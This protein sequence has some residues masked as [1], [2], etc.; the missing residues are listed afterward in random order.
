MYAVSYRVGVEDSNA[1]SSRLAVP[2]LCGGV[3]R[4]RSNE[5]VNIGNGV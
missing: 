2:A 3:V 1:A 4:D 5:S